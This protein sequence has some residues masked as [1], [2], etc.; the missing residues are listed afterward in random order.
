MYAYGGAQQVESEATIVLALHTA[1]PNSVLSVVND[2]V[3]L[4]AGYYLVTYGVQADAQDT[5]AQDDQMAS[6]T[7][8]AAGQALDSETVNAG[9]SK[10]IVYGTDAQSTLSL[11]N[12]G[13]KDIDIAQAFVTV[14]VLQ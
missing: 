13:Q 12:S 7:L 4:P 1:T 6:V 11:V 5:E 2:A 3:Q 8:Y 9:F 10:T 14:S